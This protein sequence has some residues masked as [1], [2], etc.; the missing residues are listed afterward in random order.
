[1]RA[2]D[3]ITHAENLQSNG[4]HFISHLYI[5][6]NGIEVTRVFRYCGELQG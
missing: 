3:N 2:A 1:M 5:F 4:R 6:R